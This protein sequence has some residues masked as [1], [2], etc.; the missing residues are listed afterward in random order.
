MLTLIGAMVTFI[1]DVNQSLVALR[2]ELGGD[3]AGK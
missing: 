3:Q 2:F 1:Q